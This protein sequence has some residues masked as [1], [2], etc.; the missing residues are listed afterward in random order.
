VQ[1]SDDLMNDP[2]AL[3]NDLFWEVAIGDG[4]QGFRTVGSPFVFSETP[5]AIHR[6]VPD[7]GQHTEEILGPLGTVQSARSQL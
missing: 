4:T 6:G 7:I 2:Q 5:V 3:H 1:S